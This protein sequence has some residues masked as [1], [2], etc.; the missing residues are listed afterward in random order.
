MTY[1]DARAAIESLFAAGWSPTPVAFQNVDFKPPTDGGAW[2][3]LTLEN[4][5]AVQASFGGDLRRFRCRGSAQVEIFTEA[6]AGTSQARQLA[7]IAVALFAGASV[8]GL[9]FGAASAMP[10][11]ADRSY[12]RQ[13]VLIPYWH[14]DFR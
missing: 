10:G 9:T 3:R 4:D 1:D 13:V 12:F 7:D 6:G 8:P 11:A 5:R 2:V 14:D